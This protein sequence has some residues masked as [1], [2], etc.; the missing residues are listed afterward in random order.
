[1]KKNDLKEKDLLSAREAAI[2]LNVTPQ[3]IKNY[4]YSGRIKSLKTPGGQHRIR[5]SDLNSLGF[6]SNNKEEEVTARD[7]FSQLYGQLFQNYLEI[8]KTLLISFDGREG[9]TAGHSIRVADCASSLGN[10]LKMSEKQ[11]KNLQ[12]AGLLHDVGKLEISEDIICKPGKL[13]NEEFLRLKQHPE[14]GEK[15]V[16]EVNFLKP[17]KG[18]IRHHHERYDGKGYPDGLSGDTIEL[19]ARIISLADAYDFMRSDV[20]FRKGMSKEVCLKEIKKGSGVQFDPHL[21]KVFIT[22]P[23]Q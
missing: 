15:M 18:F 17:I 3:T 6:F 14:L 10:Q 22:H 4:I 9:I 8:I 23:P 12:L 13:T 2:A 20:S 19:E 7:D 1:M 5:R 21:A 16:D 11:L